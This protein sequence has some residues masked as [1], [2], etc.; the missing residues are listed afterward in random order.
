MFGAFAGAVSYRRPGA[1]QCLRFAP[2]DTRAWDGST[3][4]AASPSRA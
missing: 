2:E 4:H 3:L 1:E